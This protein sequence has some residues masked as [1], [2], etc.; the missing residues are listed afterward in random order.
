MK[1]KRKPT[2]D[3]IL[4]DLA[5]DALMFK[6]IN[7]IASSQD[8][9]DF[10]YQVKLMQKEISSLR[11]NFYNVKEFIE[12]NKRISMFNDYTEPEEEWHYYLECD[13]NELL[14]RLQG[15]DNSVKD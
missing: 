13:A 14:N 15:D 9:F 2:F 10:E 8:K 3:Y 11:R 4:N 5:F 7:N 1:N 6:V 12:N